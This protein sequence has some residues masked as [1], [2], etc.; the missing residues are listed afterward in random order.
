MESPSAA[1]TTDAL[2][3]ALATHPE[4]ILRLFPPPSPAG[5]AL[6]TP[7]A[8]T[9]RPGP[10]RGE[11]PRV[12][13]LNRCT[14]V[15]QHQGVQRPMSGAHHGSAV[16]PFKQPKAVFAVAFACVVSFMG[17]GL[18]DPILPAISNQLHA[19]PSETTL[20]FTS[21]LVVTAVAML[22]TNWVSSR[23]GAKWTL[24]A[25]LILIVAF[26]AA[27]GSSGSISEIIEFRAGWGVGNALF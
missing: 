10:Q 11:E 5:G 3:A 8:T 18:V 9:T 27:A 20:L 15:A 24:I 13:H 22:I 1:M 16:S 17:I 12:H 14:Q 19:S 25:G 6:L 23:I 2:A 7:P 4:R 21:Y 26:S